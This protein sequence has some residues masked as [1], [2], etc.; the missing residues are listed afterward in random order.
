MVCWQM[1]E[2]S[3]CSR[4]LWIPHKSSGGALSHYPL[5]TIH[6]VAPSVHPLMQYCHSCDRI[7]ADSASVIT[8][9][10]LGCAQRL[11]ITNHGW[12]EA[13]IISAMSSVADLIAVSGQQ[14]QVFDSSG[15]V[16]CRC[17]PHVVKHTCMAHTGLHTGGQHLIY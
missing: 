10:S 12:G 13:A 9:Y 7:T 1:L 15:A 6:T 17:H 4:G 14:H 8:Q 16:L 2:G 3:L 5:L 11:E